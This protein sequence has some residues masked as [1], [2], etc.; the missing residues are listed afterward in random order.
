MLQRR[1]GLAFGLGLALPA[2]AT[3]NAPLRVRVPHQPREIDPETHYPLRVLRAAL[4]ASGQAYKLEFSQS[5]IIQARAMR[6]L[7]SDEGVIDVVWSMSSRLREQTLMAVRVPLYRGLYGWRLLMVRRGEAKRFAGVRTLKDL[8]RFRFVQGADWPDAEILA[9]NGLQVETA[10]SFESMWS[11]LAKVEVDAFPRSALE[12]WAE[13]EAQSARFEVEPLLALHYPAPMYFFVAPRRPDL[14][15][16][17]EL[18]MR[19]ISERGELE[20]L[21]QQAHGAELLRARLQQRRVIELR[22]P[23]LPSDSPGEP[24]L[25]LPPP[26]GA[27]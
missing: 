4:A 6:E 18:G 17:L 24:K 27:R 11:K 5:P 19:R 21:L 15:Q 22:N 12:I 13:S 25:V 8:K 1:A 7:E 16:A 23:L 10:G 2:H 3:T 9:A 20:N 14:A 26:S